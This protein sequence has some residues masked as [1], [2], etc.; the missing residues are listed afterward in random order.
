[1]QSFGKGTEAIKS[2]GFTLIE[3][4]VVIAVIAILAALL[5]PALSR[6]RN[7]AR[8]VACMS[9]VRQVGLG[10]MMYADENDDRWPFHMGDY[11]SYCPRNGTCQ[12]LPDPSLGG[13]TSSQIFSALIDGGY[14]DN[15]ELFSCPGNPVDINLDSPRKCISPYVEGEGEVIAYGGRDSDGYQYEKGGGPDTVGYIID[16]YMPARNRLHPM[17]AVLAG[18]L[19]GHK[20]HD[21]REGEG[22]YEVAA[23]SYIDTWQANHGSGVNVLFAD[24]HVEYVRAKEQETPDGDSFEAIA[25]PHIEEDTN[26]YGVATEKI[27]SPAEYRR[28]AWYRDAAI[29]FSYSSGSDDQPHFDPRTPLEREG[30][31]E[32][33]YSETGARWDVKFIPRSAPSPMQREVGR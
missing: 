8:R 6:A 1:M 26:I 19:S 16:T 17:R 25:N 14:I 18:R 30:E 20:F 22:D 27:K 21:W 15:K 23:Y 28:E 13:A 3:L 33:Y 5:M 10:L 12:D 29:H 4:L 31:V 9:N 32:G 11:P 7:A 2:K 24:G